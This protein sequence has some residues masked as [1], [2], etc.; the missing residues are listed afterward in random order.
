MKL[1]LII[2]VLVAVLSGIFFWQ[3]TNRF[4]YPSRATGPSLV[5]PSIDSTT[6]GGSVGVTPAAGCSL[7]GKG[8]YN[9]D[10]KID[11]ADFDLFRREYTGALTTKDSDGNGNGMIDVGDFDILR[12]GMFS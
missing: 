1:K 8:D 4:L 6:N 9:C 11:I 10:S 5:T 3:T 7:K 2:I 12:R